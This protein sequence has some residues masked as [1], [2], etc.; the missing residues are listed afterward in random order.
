MPAN[1]IKNP[2]ASTAGKNQELNRVHEQTNYNIKLSGFPES[3]PQS[4]RNTL[5]SIAL[6]LIKEGAI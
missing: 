5:T 4:L 1:L 6:R 2:T 3:F